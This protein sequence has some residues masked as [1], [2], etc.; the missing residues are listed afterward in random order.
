MSR[1]VILLF[2]LYFNHEGG[3]FLLQLPASGRALVPIIFVKDPTP[4]Y[5]P[6]SIFF[7]MEL[8]LASLRDRPLAIV[9]QPDQ[10]SFLIPV[11]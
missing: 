6:C 11:G 7:I 2:I 8:R 9:L 5:T 4:P 10:S 1:V 3:P